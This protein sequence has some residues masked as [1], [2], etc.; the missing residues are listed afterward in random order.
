LTLITTSWEGTLAEN[1]AVNFAEVFV[2]PEVADGG[3]QVVGIAEDGPACCGWGT[4]K[5]Y[6]RQLKAK[7]RADEMG[8]RQYRQGMDK[9]R[10]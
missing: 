1:F 7:S 2:G 5:A 6:S 8:F 4:R 9:K 3:G 10:K